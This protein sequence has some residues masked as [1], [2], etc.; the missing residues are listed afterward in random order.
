MDYIYNITF[1]IPHEREK[2]FLEWM[3][4]SAMVAI[5]K[6]EIKAEHVSLRMVVETGGERPGPEHGVSV[7]LQCAF[8]GEEEAHAWHDRVLPCI[9][10]EFHSEYA[11]HAAFF[12]TLLQS[13]RL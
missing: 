12:I 9:L 1:I 3:R 13:I 2:D 4:S 8:P 7:A 10:G 11:P 6:G 5:R